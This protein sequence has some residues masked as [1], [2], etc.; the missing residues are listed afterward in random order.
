[1]P[2]GVE[3]AVGEEEEGVFVTPEAFF[4]VG[5]EPG[6]RAMLPRYLLDLL[7]GVAIEDSPGEIGYG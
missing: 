7:P 3:A 4:E 2:D 6:T 1:V 5:D